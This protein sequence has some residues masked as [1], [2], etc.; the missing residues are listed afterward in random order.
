[1]HCY[2][3]LKL[4]HR[5]GFEP[6]TPRF[7]VWCSIQLSYRC[8]PFFFDHLKLIGPSFSKSNKAP[9]KSVARAFSLISC[10]QVT[11]PLV[12]PRAFYTKARNIKRT[13]KVKTNGKF[14]GSD[15][16]Q[17][18]F[19]PRRHDRRRPLC[20][21]SIPNLQHFLQGQSAAPSI[22]LV[23]IVWK[24]GRASLSASSARV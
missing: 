24:A 12:Q 21:R 5:K 19:I 8:L 7:V 16:A 11:S 3:W 15:M 13:T 9:K 6:L 18:C 17:K 23:S 14:S 22:D 1:M 10:S 20:S 2:D 4:V